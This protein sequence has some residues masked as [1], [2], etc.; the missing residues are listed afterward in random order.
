MLRKNLGKLFSRW[1]ISG[2]RAPTTGRFWLRGLTVVGYSN[3]PRRL[4]GGSGFE[5]NFRKRHLARRPET[6]SGRGRT[7]F[8][9]V[10][11]FRGMNGACS[12]RVSRSCD[13]GKSVESTT[14]RR[15]PNPILSIWSKKQERSRY[16]VTLNSS[17][18]HKNTWLPCLV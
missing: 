9:S 1:Y 2:T 7:D 5:E 3:W 12:V 4:R 13:P 6:G 11:N 16:S 10:R 8:R 17:T 18:K 14:C 15:A